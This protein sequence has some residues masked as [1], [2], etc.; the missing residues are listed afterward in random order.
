MSNVTKHTGISQISQVREEILWLSCARRSLHINERFDDAWTTTKG[1]KKVVSRRNPPTQRGQCISMIQESGEPQYKG[2][3]LMKDVRAC[4]SSTFPQISKKNRLG[5]YK[6]ER[7]LSI[8]AS[9]TTIALSN[10][11]ARSYYPQST[12]HSRS[13]SVARLHALVEASTNM[14]PAN[15]NR[16]YQH[17][18]LRQLVH[19]T[20]ASSCIKPNQSIPDKLR[21]YRKHSTLHCWVRLTVRGIAFV[22]PIPKV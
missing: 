9:Y 20:T 11:E 17:P 4:E 15:D 10:L 5:S 19:D 6:V 13:Q 12:S 16:V 21:S 1:P 14:S 3:L 2:I 18:R 22:S 8:Y 7:E